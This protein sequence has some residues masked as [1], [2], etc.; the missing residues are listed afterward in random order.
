V[1]PPPVVFRRT[2]NNVPS[3]P[4]WTC[5]T[6]KLFAYTAVKSTM[7]YPA[8]HAGHSLS[9]QG[10]AGSAS[11]AAL[12]LLVVA[13]TNFSLAGLLFLLAFLTW[14]ASRTQPEQQRAKRLWAAVSGKGLV[15]ARHPSC[16]ACCIGQCRSPCSV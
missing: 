4:K 11:L 1:L 12:T 9:P 14:G 5:R 13:Y 7:Q 10:G 2:L 6:H 3:S 15:V 16:P 8:Q